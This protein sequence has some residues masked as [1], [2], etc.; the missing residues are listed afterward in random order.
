MN[1]IEDGA[2][3][4]IVVSVDEASDELIAIEIAFTSGAFKGS[5]TTLRASMSIDRALGMLGL[6]VTLRVEEGRPRIT[7]D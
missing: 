7:I 1:A 4:V 5:S 3:D 6:P 2:Y